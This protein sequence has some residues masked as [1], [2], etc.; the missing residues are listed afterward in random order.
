MARCGSGQDWAGLLETVP[1]LLRLAKS[2]S[3][4][5]AD[6]LAALAAKA[7]RR[8]SQVAALALLKHAFQLRCQA[9]GEAGQ[10]TAETHR[11]L[12]RLYAQVGYAEEALE[13]HL[14]ALAL[15]KASEGEANAAT[16][17]CYFEIG[18][19]YALRGLELEDSGLEHADGGSAEDHRRMARKYLAAA[20]HIYTIPALRLEEDSM[21]RAMLDAYRAAALVQDFSHVQLSEQLIASARATAERHLQQAASA[22][23]GADAANAKAA[24]ALKV[25]AAEVFHIS[26]RVAGQSQLTPG[27]SQQSL[28]Y[29]AR[30]LALMEEAH[31]DVPH[32]DTARMA[33]ELSYVYGEEQDAWPQASAQA[34]K[35]LALYRTA[36]GRESP[37]VLSALLRAYHCKVQLGGYALDHAHSAARVA[38]ACFGG[39]SYA[40]A[41]A[42]GVLAK[43]EFK[44]ARTAEDRRRAGHHLEYAALII[45]NAQSG[46]TERMGHR[47]WWLSRGLAPAAA[48]PTFQLA[49]CVFERLPLDSENA[50]ALLSEAALKEVELMEASCLWP[51]ED[52]DDA[53]DGGAADGALDGIKALPEEERLEV[54]A[55]VYL[56]HERH[57]LLSN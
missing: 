23:N 51:E 29:A 40:Y 43:E 56:P 33:L 22:A 13:H 52:E 7:D 44:T 4:Q 41:W 55:W 45:L 3:P 16:A 48:L 46:P 5:H 53:V 10:L 2:S 21:E 6:A 38:H 49:R 9:K 14:A 54:P 24:L 37:R 12:A 35:A 34:T 19:L 18:R 47:L 15:V 42:L 30:A 8:G 36:T 11:D 31:G 32:A 39:R 50:D 28:T 27:T 17:M 1:G 57:H 20:H 25:S 26:S